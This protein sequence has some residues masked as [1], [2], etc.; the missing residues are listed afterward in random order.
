MKFK[1]KEQVE[2][3]KEGGKILARILAVLKG[4]VKPGVTTMHLEVIAK[5]LLKE[6]NAEGS[7]LGYHPSF[8]EKP[9]PASLCT[10]VNEE[11][12]HAIPSERVLKEGDI[13]SLDFGVKYKGLMTDAAITVPVGKISKEAEKLIRVTKESLDVAIQ[14]AQIGKRL[15]DIGFAIQNHIEKNGFHVVKELCGH[16]VGFDVHEEPEV[17]NFGGK[18]RGML[19][20]EGMVVAIEPMVAIGDAR[21]K[22]SKDGFGYE[23]MDGS[24]SAHFEHTI[25]VMKDGPEILTL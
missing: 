23:T 6:N 20:K 5:K 9:Y 3:M 10:C 12:V 7:F 11:I 13:L 17:L 4:E 24:L 8:L 18:G 1:T 2:I 19:L 21:I 16:G 14:E 25:A 15:G 22:K